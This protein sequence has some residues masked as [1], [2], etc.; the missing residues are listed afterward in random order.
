MKTPNKKMLT[1][2][3]NTKKTIKGVADYFEVSVST[4]KNWLEEK[5]I[6]TSTRTAVS[7]DKIRTLYKKMGLNEVAEKLNCSRSTIRRRMIENNIQRR[8]K[9]TR[10]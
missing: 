8:T 9:G 1:K 2:A 3:Y 6:K 10:V 4:A 7:T 5:N